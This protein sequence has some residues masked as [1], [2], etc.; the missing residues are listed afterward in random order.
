VENDWGHKEYVPGIP[1]RQ[2]EIQ[3]EP[4]EEAEMSEIEKD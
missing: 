3:A 1:V 2:A 4:D